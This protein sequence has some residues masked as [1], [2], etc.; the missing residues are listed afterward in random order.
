[1]TLENPVR[2]LPA[3]RPDRDL[4]IRP[5]GRHSPILKEGNRVHRISVKAKNLLSGLGLERPSDGGGVEA[6]RQ[7]IVAIT[8]NRNRAHGSTVTCQLRL[9]RR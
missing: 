6:A 3:W 1:M 4:R 5:S 8:G 9:R 2:L 7:N